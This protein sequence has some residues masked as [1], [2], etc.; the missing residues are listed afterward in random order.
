MEPK[1]F[2]PPELTDRSRRVL[3]TVCEAAPGAFLI[4]GWGTWVRIGGAMSHDID[5]IV[6]HEQLAAVTALGADTSESRHVG[7][8]K[9]RT[10]VDGIHVDLYV[11][12]QSRLGQALRLR[13][14]NLVHD[15]EVVDGWSVLSLPAHLATKLAALTDRPQTAPGIKDRYE[16]AALIS[17]QL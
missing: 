3:D 8:R 11:A 17:R 2:Y 14:E 7:G 15:S 6:T 9:W 16:A 13:V 1:P 5:L 4:G 10:I 12:Y